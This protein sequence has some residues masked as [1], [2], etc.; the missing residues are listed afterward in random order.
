MS[1]RPVWRN[2]TS[3]SGSLTGTCFNNRP[4]TAL[5]IAVFAPMPNANDRRTTVV[6]PL[7]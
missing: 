4:L 5:K 1:L 6:H 3:E 7:A 2:R